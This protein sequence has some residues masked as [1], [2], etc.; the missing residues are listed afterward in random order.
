MYIQ[1]K[2]LRKNKGGTATHSTI[3]KKDLKTSGNVL[4]DNRRVMMITQRRVTKNESNPLNNR[5]LFF[6]GVTDNNGNENLVLPSN[7]VNAGKKE[8]EHSKKLHD[9]E[10]NALGDIYSILNT[11]A[12]TVGTPMQSTYGWIVLR[13]SAAP[14]KLC[15][16]AIAEMNNE[17]PN[18]GITVKYSGKKTHKESEA[19]PG[20]THGY[21]GKGVHSHDN[22]HLYM[23][24]DA[25]FGEGQSEFDRLFNNYVKT[26]FQGNVVLFLSSIAKDSKGA[27]KSAVDWVDGLNRQGV[28]RNE[29]IDLTEDKK[30]SIR[31]EIEFKI[32]SLEG[33]AKSI[34][35]GIPTAPVKQVVVNY[36]GNVNASNL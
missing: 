24:N 29:K 28:M 21:D 11:H 12:N 35:G 33:Y 9:A 31:T 36:E 1:D 26:N 2:Q 8:S 15:K 25:L 13:V 6:S 22:I 14:C 5:A 18:V 4:L 17:L 32:S 27:V 19:F 34:S 16:Q 23:S 7:I 10:R 3:Q 30:K 20:L